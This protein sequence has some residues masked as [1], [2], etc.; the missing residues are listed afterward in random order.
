MRHIRIA[1]RASKLALVQANYIHDL[2]QNLSQD[3]EITIVKVS[4]KGDRDKSDFLY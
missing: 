3:I 1:S 4:T 2:L